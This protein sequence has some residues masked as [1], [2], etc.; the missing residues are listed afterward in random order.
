VHQ[1]GN[2]QSDTTEKQSD[3]LKTNP[4][5]C[6]GDLDSAAVFNPQ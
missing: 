3:A 1:T 6:F 2:A 4:R 5:L